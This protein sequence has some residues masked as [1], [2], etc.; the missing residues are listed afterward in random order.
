MF[1]YLPLLLLVGAVAL[2][3]LRAP[4]PADAAFVPDRMSTGGHFT[5]PNFLTDPTVKVSFGG[6]IQCD[7][8]DPSNL[9]VHY[10]VQ[11]EFHLETVTSV[12]CT[13]NNPN[14]SNS[15]GQL[16]ATGTGTCNG[17]PAQAFRIELNDTGHGN[18]GDSAAFQVLGTVPGCTYATFARAL[19]GGQL[20]LHTD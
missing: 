20:T 3:S 13:L 11:A 15:G 19:E 14:D 8:S 6:V 4:A 7:G 9:I 10:R 17:A 2:V 12:T 16:V 5:E 18:P 1:R